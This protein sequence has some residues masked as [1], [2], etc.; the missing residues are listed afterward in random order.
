MPRGP[1]APPPAPRQRARGRRAS[2]SRARRPPSEAPTAGRR[3]AAPT[4][5]GRAPTGRAPARARSRTRRASWSVTRS[6]SWTRSAYSR[7]ERPISSRP[8]G[9]SATS[10]ASRSWS[11]SAEAFTIGTG[12]PNA[13][14][15]RRVASSW[16]N[17]TTGLP[18]AMHSIAK[19]PYQPAFSWSTTMSASRYRSSA[20]LWWSPSTIRSSTS[21]SS[22]ARTTWSVPLR[23]RD[24]GAWTT[25][26]RRRPD[27]GAGVTRARS[28]PGG[29]TVAWGTQRIAS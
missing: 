17:V 8:D 19:R 26:G 12:S 28:M 25:T 7:D 6:R 21:S 9:P 15:V 27:G 18:S 1:A 23:R 5:P 2:P 3:P 16:R 22:Q 11:V 14:S 10:S 24:E 20:S 4:G 29:I 13:S